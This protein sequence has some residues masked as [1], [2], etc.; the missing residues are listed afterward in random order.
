MGAYNRPTKRV[1]RG[2]FYLDDGVVINSLSAVE[3]GKV[4]E[5]VA[6][7]NSARDGGFAAGID[8]HAAKVDG[9]RKSSSSFEEEMVRTRTRFSVFELWYQHLKSSKA[10]GTFNEWGPEALDDVRP[11]DTIELRG[12]LEVAPIQTLF[13]LYLWFAEKAK[14]SGHMFSQS[15]DS[16]KQTKNAERIVQMMLGDPSEE[17]DQTVV[18]AT[19]MGESGPRVAM[20]V[21]SKWLIGKFG[22]FGGEYT[23]IGQVDR[24]VAS[25]EE[26][27]ALRLTHDVAA[28]ELEVKTLKSSIANFK[29]PARAMGIGVSDNDAVVEGPAL[30]IE[31]IAIYR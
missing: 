22:Q 26:I 15:G 31:P 29:D 30:W 4:D 25:N 19:P 12:S 24:L 28:T 2:F 9:S 7:V 21:K 1:H 16:L 5:V 14:I 10:L 8:M 23:V 17:D 27:P 11:G 18:L 20:A 13:R 6:K 3:S